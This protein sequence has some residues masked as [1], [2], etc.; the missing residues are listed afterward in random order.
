MIL[1]AWHVPLKA[2]QWFCFRHILFMVYLVPYFLKIC[3][4]CWWFPFK[5]VPKCSCAVYYFK[6]KAVTHLPKEKCVGWV[7]FRQEFRPIRVVGPRAWAWV[8][9]PSSGVVET[10]IPESIWIVNFSSNANM[11]NNNPHFRYWE[12]SNCHLR[13]VKALLLHQFGSFF[14]L[15]RSLTF[16]RIHKIY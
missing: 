2:E 1:V 9:T 3:T 13:W 14:P 6:C 5:M 12:K 4:F 7:F 8:V 10:T 16:I 11:Q 15:I